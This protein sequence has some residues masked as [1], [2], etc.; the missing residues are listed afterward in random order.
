MKA[1]IAKKRYKRLEN[2]ITELHGQVQRLERRAKQE[3]A[4]RLPRECEVRRYCVD[5]T[6]NKH[7]WEYIGAD[8]LPF[9]RMVLL[10][11]S[12]P[13]MPDTT[14]YTLL[15]DRD[16]SVKITP[17]TGRILEHIVMSMI[18]GMEEHDYTPADEDMYLKKEMRAEAM[19]AKYGFVPP[20]EALEG[21][22]K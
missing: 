22:K 17:A 3:Q 15:A 20:F 4:F 1:R 5:H 14:T 8:D 16:E 21:D 2:T 18:T 11:H 13:F 7:D 9:I 6:L 19:K 10:K 12:V